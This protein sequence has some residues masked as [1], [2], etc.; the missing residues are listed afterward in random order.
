MDTHYRHTILFGTFPLREVKDSFKAE[1]RCLSWH[2]WCDNLVTSTK[3]W[4]DN[5]SK[6]HE[7]DTK[8]ILFSAT[9]TGSHHMPH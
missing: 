4:E 9:P 1:R 2:S 5:R 7:V 8:K 6:M 3:L